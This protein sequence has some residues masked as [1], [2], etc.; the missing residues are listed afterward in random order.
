MKVKAESTPTRCEICHQNDCFDPTTNYCS[1]CSWINP[2]I[3]AK[4]VVDKTP[5]RQALSFVL[6]NMLVGICGAIILPL[7][8]QLK[9]ASGDFD[10]NNQDYLL[11]MAV[12]GGYA[13]LIGSLFSSIFSLQIKDICWRCIAWAGLLVIYFIVS[14]I[15]YLFLDEL[16]HSWLSTSIL[17]N[18]LSLAITLALTNKLLSGLISKLNRWIIFGMF[19]GAIINPLYGLLITMPGRCGNPRIAAVTIGSITGVIWGG[20]IGLIVVGAIRL[21]QQCRFTSRARH[22]NE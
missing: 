10:A 12:F 1:R 4:L 13:S 7:M 22:N 2:T 6:E 15:C 5:L 11:L 19:I 18:P 21:C 3:T 17:W 14:F 20:I 9:N 8:Y 16:P